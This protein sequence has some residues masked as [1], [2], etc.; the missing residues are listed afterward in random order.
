MSEATGNE[1]K[2]VIDTNGNGLS[3]LSDRSV[4]DRDITAADTA[5]EIHLRHYFSR[6]YR[7]K[8]IVI[9]VAAVLMTAAVLYLVTRERVYRAETRVQVDFD[10]N[11]GVAAPTGEP[12]TFVDRAYFNTQLELLTSPGMIRRVVKN[13]NLDQDQN[14]RPSAPATSGAD[15]VE[16]APVG[17]DAK[18]G[19]R[20]PDAERLAPY[21]E[22]V[23]DSLD[24][25]PVLRARQAVKDTRLIEIGYTHADPVIAARITNTLAD[26]LIAANLERKTS[27]NTTENKYLQDNIN[28]LT[29]QIKND[30]QQLLAFGRNYQL[31]TLEGSQNTVVERLVGLNQQLLVAENDRKLAEAAYRAAMEPGAAEALA[32]EGSKQI[33]DID[34]KLDELRQRRAQLLVEVTE[35]YPEVREIDDQIAVLQRQAKERRSRATD[36]YSKNLDTRYRQAAARET[37]IKNAFEVQRGNTLEQNE[38]AINYRIIQQSIETNKKLLDGMKQRSN[39][40]DMLLAKVPNN[41]SVVDYASAPNEP[42]TPFGLQY[43]LLAGVLSL[44]AGL[45]LALLRDYFDDVV[46]TT[47]EIETTLRLPAL[48]AVPRIKDSL[49]ARR[50]IVQPASLQLSDGEAASPVLNRPELILAAEADS[51][52]GEAFRRLKTTLLM[53][54]SF[55]KLKTI[56]VTSS[57]KSEGKTTTAV[58]LATSLSQSGA[59]V[60]IVDADLRNPSVHR[61]FGITSGEGLTDVLLQRADGKQASDYIFGYS[62]TLHL[63]P[64]GAPISD[65]A[66]WLASGEFQSI[67]DDLAE[68]YDHVIIDSPPICA[69]ADSTILAS[70]ADG[71]LLVVQGSRVSQDT[72]RQSAKALRMVGANIVGVVMNKVGKHDDSYY[73]YGY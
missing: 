44:G 34:A 18:S 3:R 65:S 60:L 24:V 31:P 30:E 16:A 53:S 33:A 29:A 8:F 11:G 26:E 51:P 17:D 5:D 69:F 9:G 15:V 73:G 52:V 58:N 23:Q 46:H 14:F 38:A 67:I 50:R 21:V 2:R 20:D 45:G 72:V 32:E 66:D 28:E 64:A 19:E 39:E 25:Q 22:A 10:N 37:A 57:E 42:M 55:G 54:P 68:T 40:S 70:R 41:I 12:S 47:S 36:V 48:A 61:I 35:K 27:V 62:S 63:L 43:F 59:S 1:I 71:V 49:L 6:V 56:L 13:L 4:M 7:H